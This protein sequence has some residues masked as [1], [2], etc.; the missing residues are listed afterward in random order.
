MYNNEDYILTRY[1]NPNTHQLITVQY[2][3]DPQ[4]P[5]END[6]LT[7]DDNPALKFVI[8]KFNT[9]DPVQS[10][11]D[12]LFHGDPDAFR[13][14]HDKFNNSKDLFNDLRQ[15]ANSQGYTILPITC[16]R[17]SEVNYYLGA[18]SGWD[19]STCGYVLIDDQKFSPDDLKNTIEKYIQPILSNITDYVNGNVYEVSLEQLNVQN[20]PI[21]DN[22][23]DSFE[24]CRSDFD[25]ENFNRIADDF[26][27]DDQENW[28]PATIITHVSYTPKSSWLLPLTNL[29]IW[30]NIY[31][32]NKYYNTYRYNNTNYCKPTT[33]S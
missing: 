11:T 3:T 32:N 6:Y 4:N 27:L 24:V 30:F 7:A 17:H 29:L 26:E 19:T 5:L 2:S 16:Y 18:D 9:K 14:E 13:I 8:D 21:E 15:I 33:N 31:L 28:Q 12:D 20:E 1:I 22:Y 25:Y 10:L 23:L